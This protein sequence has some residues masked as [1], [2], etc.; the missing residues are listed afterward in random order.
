[1]LKKILYIGLIGCFIGIFAQAQSTILYST[2]NQISSSLINDIYQDKEGFIWI[3]TEYGLNRF[4]GNKFITYNHIDEDSTSLCNDYIHQTFED[5]KGNLWVSSMTGLMKYDRNTNSFTPI[6]LYRN[7]LQV[8]SGINQIIESKEGILW[9]T[10]SGEGLFQIN[11]E[12]LKGQCVIPIYQAGFRHLST[13]LDD[14]KGNLWIGSENDGLIHYN[15][16]NA[17]IKIFKKPEISEDNISSLAKDPYGNIYIG[18]LSGGLNIYND[19]SKQ[20]RPIVYKGRHNLQITVLTYTNNRLYIGTDGEGLKTYIPGEQEMHDIPLEDT[21]FDLTNKKIH[22]IL[23]DRN[24]DLWLGLFQRGVALISMRHNPFQYHGYKSLYGNPIGNKCIM[25][26]LE[27]HRGQLFVGTDNDG[28]YI[29]DKQFTPL[30]HLLPNKS[31]HSVANTILAI[32]QDSDNEIWLGT[33]TKGACKLNLNQQSCDYIPELQNERVFA[34]TEDKNRNLY[35][36]SYG[37]GLYV[38]N[39]DK[40]QITQYKSLEKSSETKIYNELPNNWIN[41]LYCDKEGLI[42]IGHFEG[43]TCFNPKTK[44]FLNFNEQNY[45]LKGCI[46]Y[47]I[48]ED[49][50]GNIWAGT[51]NGLYTFNRQTGEIKRYS[52]QEGLGNN[53]VCGICEDKFGN[54]WVS[55]FNGISRLNPQTQAFTT[56]HSGD[57]LQG[58]EFT[59]GAFFQSDKGTIYFGGTN[60]ITSFMPEQIISERQVPPVTITDFRVSGQSINTQTLSGGKPIIK[61]SVTEA[62]RFRLSYKDNTFSIS[63]S[64]LQFAQAKQIVYK[65]RIKELDEDWQTTAL[66]ANYVTYNNLTHGKYTFEVFAID[67]GYNS[68]IKT[69]TILITPPWFLSWWAYILYGILILLIIWAFISYT[70][71]RWKQRKEIVERKHAEEISEAKLQFFINI[72]HEIRT[73]LTLIITPMEKLIA[74]C[75][76][77]ELNKTYLMIYRNSQ[78]ILRLI[79]QLMDIRKIDKGQMILKFKET[80]L[81]KFIEDFVNTFSYLAQNKHITFTFEHDDKQQKAWIDQNNFDKILMNLLSNAFKYTPEGGHVTVV[82]KTGEDDT[83]KSPLKKYIELS[84]KDTGIGLNNEQIERIFERFYQIN[85]DITRNQA[86][87]GVGLH[88]TRS[89][90][91]LH[92]GT[93]IAR[94]RTDQQGSEFI[95][96]IPQGCN[97]L[98]MEELDIS[99]NT[100]PSH[101]DPEQ[102]EKSL[103]EDTGSQEE[104]IDPSKKIKT[105]H[106]LHILIVD[107][108]KEIREYLKNELETEYKVSICSNGAEAYDFLLSNSVQLIISDVMMPEMDGI[109][110]CRKIRANANINHIPII[111]LT[112][113]GRTEE[114][115]EGIETGA[116]SYII[117][118]FSIKVLQSTITNLIETRKLLKNKFSG[119]QEQNDKIQPVQLIS[120][121]EVL[122]QRIMKIINDNIAE[123]SLSVEMLANSVGLSRVHLHRKLKEITNLSPRDFI[124]NIRMQQAAKLLKEKRLSISDV[125]YAVGYNNLSHFSNTFKDLF[126]QTPKEYMQNFHDEQEPFQFELTE[127]PDANDA[128]SENMEEQTNNETVENKDTNNQDEEKSMNEN[129]TNGKKNNVTE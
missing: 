82:L 31:I 122:M 63:F 59:R 26:V 32:F 50:Y 29:L 101:R 112:A 91:Q 79:N 47:T 33:Y 38:Y 93:I 1:M 4:D 51:S 12:N 39:K 77:V 60:G 19:S 52:Q 65:Y 109:T 56:Y 118:P 73:P 64:T 8:F 13:V 43:I 107:D 103:Q 21:T 30:N 28:L 6:P 97:H 120:S 75:H 83:A 86:G 104:T 111:L 87:T 40:K 114:Q 99:E 110:L 119:A 18:T 46:G 48:T 49:R 124:R 95:I 113:K 37:A 68:E 123:P 127:N 129:T 94:N 57:G 22:A 92:Y 85:N 106:N 10:S 126:G 14:G 36:S 62:D 53:I 117:K 100:P 58:N 9:A 41:A 72:S 3:S 84:I 116:D 98:K 5:S 45:I 23:F 121:N 71:T 78:R 80:D 89:L 102:L 54:I 66:G 24:N 61:T 69:I 35:F 128:D 42:W 20:I 15:P 70:R 44:S 17:T 90:V 16:R 105:K 7:Q 27:D 25:S 67:H 108:E 2:D 115:T 88:L 55:T 96:H 76:D 81:V 125:A 74:Q 34:I 11:A